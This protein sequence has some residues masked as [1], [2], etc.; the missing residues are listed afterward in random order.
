MLHRLCL[1]A[2]CRAPPGASCVGIHCVCR[3]APAQ[4]AKDEGCT[5]LTGGGRVPG[6]AKGFWVQPTVFMA[7]PKDTL[8][9]EEV[10]Q[11]AS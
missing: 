9:R 8:W 11:R 2:F 3:V 5:L 10:R 4:A 7:T 1:H 6:K